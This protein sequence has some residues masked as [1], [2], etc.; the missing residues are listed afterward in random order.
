ML[1]ASFDYTARFWRFDEQRELSQLAGHD[2]PVNGAIFGPLDNRAVTVGAD[3]QV[4]IWDLPSGTP[5]YQLN[6]HRG[7]A[8]SVTIAPDGKTIL[9]GGWDGRLILWDLSRGTKIASYETR[10]PITAVAIGGAGKTLIAGGRDGVVRILRRGDGT[11]L[12]RINAHNIGLTQL[13]SSADGR[14]LLTIGLDN[15]ARVWNLL[16][17]RPIFEYLPEPSIK[18]VSAALSADGAAMLVGYVDGSLLYLDGNT[19]EIK[20]RI[21]AESGPVWAVAFTP[22]MR[23]ALTAGA[24]ERVRV[25]HL[26]S[27]DRIDVRADEVGER[28]M[29]W[30]ESDHPGARLYRKCAN[31]H[32]LTKTE[33]QRS[34]PHFS[35]LFGRPA[36]TVAGYRYSKALVGSEIVWSDDTIAE[37]FRQG[38]DHYLPGTKMPVQKIGSEQS[39]SDL[40][41]YLKEIVPAE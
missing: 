14:R 3:G 17:L 6:G 36:G 22:D 11:T 12:A 23:F 40:I 26:E 20:R 13:V 7:R 31:C 32:A 4:I 19:G 24:A 41:A 18:P 21:E 10:V 5:L 16:D 33:I 9:T 37:L 1:T 34:G 8:M 2:G 29:P 25:W 28:P 38:P 15:R 35:G 27:G 30:L 39:L